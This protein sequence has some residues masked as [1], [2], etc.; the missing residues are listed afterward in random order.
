[1]RQPVL[2]A[3]LLLAAATVGSPAPPAQAQTP[4]AD[5]LRIAIEDGFIKFGLEAGMLGAWQHRAFWDLSRRFAPT[6]PFDPTLAWAEGYVKPSVVFERRLSAQVVGYG[7]LSVVA[8]GTAPRD[9]FAS[10]NSGRILLEDAF[11]GLR[12][13]TPGRGFYADVSAGAQPYRIGS[14]MLIADGGADGFERGAVVSGPRRAWA[15]TALAKVGYGPV[16]I[17]AFYLDPNELASSDT[18]T[19]IAGGKAEWT[20]GPTDFVGVAYG[21][22]LGSTAPYPQVPPGGLG[23]PVIIPDARRGLQFVNTYLRFNPLGS[24]APGF[25]VAGD[26]AFQRNER[27]RLTA[28]A[29][30]VEVGRTFA[31]LPFR[32]TFSY[33]FQTFSG[34]KPGTTALE[35]FDP[36]FY[37]G[38]QNAWASGSNGSLVFINSNINAHRFSAVFTVT[39]QDILTLRYTH[40]RANELNSPIQF[41][42]GTRITASGGS[43]GLIAGVPSPH[44]SDDFIVEYTRVLTPNAF[45][46]IGV[47]H[48]IPGS[49]LRAAAAPTRLGGWSGGFA[50]LVIKY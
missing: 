30:R 40:I 27:I 14:G 41:G 32:P 19:R 13:G 29:G 38:G 6:S 7:G 16:S 39:P 34:D 31:E 4:P 42:Q 23:P 20:L 21:E 10:G 46:T 48:S 36:L 11:A 47:A 26:I 49:G 9:F 12:F 15:M 50:N 3:L 5:P 17:E 43:P 8:S 24:L 2:K 28:W 22:V 44:L 37:D 25:W 1:M 35:R 33:A 18:R 45:L